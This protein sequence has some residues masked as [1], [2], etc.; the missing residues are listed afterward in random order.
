[1]KHGFKGA[2][3]ASDQLQPLKTVLSRSK[4]TVLELGTGCGVVGIALA[5]FYPGAKI[6]VT[7]LPDAEELAQY[8]VDI[9]RLGNIEYQNLDWAEEIPDSVKTN[10]LDLILVYV[11]VFSPLSR[12]L[13]FR[14]GTRVSNT[15]NKS[16]QF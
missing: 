2:N 3:S 8:N 10:G 16:Q 1:M 13:P 14:Q 6:Q 4:I 9:A 12:Y 15:A 11:K 5:K 7:D